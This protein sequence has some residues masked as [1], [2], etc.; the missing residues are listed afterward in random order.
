MCRNGLPVSFELAWA[1]HELEKKISEDP[2]LSQLFINPLTNETYKE[3][4][5]L[6]YPK[7]ADTLE[8]VAGSGGV[9]TFYN[10]ELSRVIVQENNLKGKMAFHSVHVATRSSF[11]VAY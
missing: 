10:G 9:Q 4:E 3:N 8:K 7:L 11:K 1:I 2:G 5:L 6:K